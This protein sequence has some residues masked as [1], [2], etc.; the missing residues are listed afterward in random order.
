MKEK[1]DLLSFLISYI[2][3]FVYSFIFFN[4]I[5]ISIFLSFFLSLIFK[6]LIFELLDSREYKNKRI[7]FREFLDIFNSNVI[8][9]EN[10]YKSMKNTQKEMYAIFPEEE[11]INKN[12]KRI[13]LDI[14][15]GKNITEALL[16]FKYNMQL[17]DVD[18]FVDTLSIAI[19]SGIN[20]SDVTQLSKDM[21][22]E[23][24]SLDIEISTIID[25]SKREFIIMMILPLI[26][27]IMT[28]VTTQRNTE[29][30]EYIIRIPIFIIF[31]FSFYLG[32]KIV[33]LEV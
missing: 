5:F 6:N 7:L 29:F 22:S 27:L 13:N 15:N 17:E 31:I 21:L 19:K 1:K 9:G 23:N 16:N 10:F 26:V 20:L 11:F 14:D 4:S 28:T 32:N 33:N 12:I 3:F 18:I 8:S 24:I 25:N 2:I 30:I